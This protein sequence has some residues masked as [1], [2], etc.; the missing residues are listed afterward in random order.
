MKE[1]DK[2]YE[3]DYIVEPNIYCASFY[4][5]IQ[6]KSSEE[7]TN[8]YIAEETYFE[9]M[10]ELV[11]TLAKDMKRH[12]YPMNEN[13]VSEYELESFFEEV[14]RVLEEAGIEHYIMFR[15]LRPE[16]LK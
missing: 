3:K 4:C 12:G 14:H 16:F 11:D 13:I 2:L 9:D 7:E 1:T 5:D 6:V 15:D 8:N 10:K